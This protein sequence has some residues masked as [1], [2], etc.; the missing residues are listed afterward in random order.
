MN[1]EAFVRIGKQL[2]TVDLNMFFSN[3]V[4]ARVLL[5]LFLIDKNIQTTV[6]QGYNDHGYNE[7]NQTIG[8]V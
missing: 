2:Y 4:D 7:Q 6:E 1:W 5:F 3:D 8:L